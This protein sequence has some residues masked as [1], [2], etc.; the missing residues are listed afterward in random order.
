MLWTLITAARASDAD[1]PEY[2]E[3][4]QAAVAA[5]DAEAVADRT[6]FP[7]GTWDLYGK[8]P[9]ALA[10]EHEPG[11]LQLDRDQFVA[12]WPYLFDRAARK[13]IAAA[14]PIEVLDGMGVGIWSGKDWTVW[15]QFNPDDAGDWRLN[16]TQNVS[17]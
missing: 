8:L 10:K 3:A 16:S 6:Q 14:R 17:E 4:F 5:R 11:F 1:W 2:L 15:L 13:R 9:K 7:F 12:A